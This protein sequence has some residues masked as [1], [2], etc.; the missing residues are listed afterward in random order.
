M[1]SKSNFEKFKIN[2][3]RETSRIIN[4]LPLSAEEANILKN[5]AHDLINRGKDENTI[6]NELDIHAGRNFYKPYKTNEQLLTEN[7]RE[8]KKKQ[9]IIHPPLEDTST[10]KDV[11][12]YTK[13]LVNPRVKNAANKEGTAMEHERKFRKKIC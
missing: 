10:Y 2:M 3:K 1:T 6:I 12:K 11:K 8:K 7:E 5:E 4:Q 9:D 13:E